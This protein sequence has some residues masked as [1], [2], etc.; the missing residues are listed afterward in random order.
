MGWYRSGNLEDTEREWF[1]KLKSEKE[2][3][4]KKLMFAVAAIAAGAVFAEEAAP[5]VQAPTVVG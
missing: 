1:L 5:A 2:N 3:I 4:M